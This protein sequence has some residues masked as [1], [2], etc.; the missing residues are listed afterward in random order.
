[1][2]L[3]V[4]NITVSTNGFSIMT[5]GPMLEDGTYSAVPRD[6]VYESLD[7]YVRNAPTIGN[8]VR[9]VST[10]RYS[11]TFYTEPPIYIRSEV[12]FNDLIQYLETRPNL[13]ATPVT[14][15]RSG[16]LLI[17]TDHSIPAILN[18]DV[19]ISVIRRLSEIVAGAG[20]YP[21][22]DVQI[23]IPSFEV[24]S[25]S[26]PGDILTDIRAGRLD[27]TIFN[28]D[29]YVR[30]SMY[31]DVHFTNTH[32][33]IVQALDTLAPISIPAT[34]EHTVQGEDHLLADYT[35]DYFGEPTREAT[36]EATD[37]RLGAIQ[38]QP[39]G[40]GI[41]TLEGITRTIEEI[42]AALHTSPHTSPRF[43]Q[44]IPI[45][46]GVNG[47]P[48]PDF[49]RVAPSPIMNDAIVGDSINITSQYLGIIPAGPAIPI[50]SYLTEMSID[51][52][53]GGRTLVR[54]RRPP[55]GRVRIEGSIDAGLSGALAERLNR[56]LPLGMVLGHLATQE[57]MQGHNHD[58][59]REQSSSAGPIGNNRG[60][61][62][63]SE[64][65]PADSNLLADLERANLSFQQRIKELE[66]SN[67]MLMNTIARLDTEIRTKNEE[68]S[69][70]NDILSGKKISLADDFRRVIMRETKHYSY[71][72]ELLSAEDRFNKVLIGNSY[73]ELE[74]W[75]E[76]SINQVYNGSF[77]HIARVEAIYAEMARR[78]TLIV[79]DP[80]IERVRE[81]VHKRFMDVLGTGTNLEDGNIISVALSIVCS[82]IGD[83]NIIE[84]MVEA[85]FPN[86]MKEEKEPVRRININE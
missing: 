33:N 69:R 65:I 24:T 70:L 44:H 64:Y 75:A 42:R 58:L 57:Q 25:S 14:V 36:R 82:I 18:S 28:E 74:R 30:V 45:R 81:F 21:T 35:P 59:N 3:D 19:L 53:Y 5:H 76:H 31:L 83:I 27:R 48:L 73:E 15:H 13:Q 79:R 20:D 62:A 61:S 40:D 38:T 55:V 10:S 7:N 80:D 32:G 17:H 34:E 16:E 71:T 41:T 78:G 66:E 26:Y 1:M 4:Q 85:K 8:L 67:I 77:H 9:S 43:V 54:R 72:E 2:I 47:I 23:R 60:T 49:S 84:D 6:L 56:G 52:E 12:T 29:A 39:F 46:E 37:S 11:R 22:F 51:A 68:I 63:N 86:I 50:D